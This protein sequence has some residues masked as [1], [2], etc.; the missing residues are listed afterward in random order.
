MPT[1]KD[2][3]EIWRPCFDF[4]NGQRIPFNN[5]FAKVYRRLDADNY[6]VTIIAIRAGANKGNGNHMASLEYMAYLLVTD[7]RSILA[8]GNVNRRTSEDHLVN[9]PFVCDDINKTLS[10]IKAIGY[11]DGSNPSCRKWLIVDGMFDPFELAKRDQ[12][13]AHVQEHRNTIIKRRA[14]EQLDCSALATTVLTAVKLVRADLSDELQRK[15]AT[16][17]A[18]TIERIITAERVD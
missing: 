7:K 6:F 3:S 2:L 13:K 5:S 15:I 1:A 10:F 14:K 18:P 11:A 9:D 4:R 8:C 16:R 12:R 17:I